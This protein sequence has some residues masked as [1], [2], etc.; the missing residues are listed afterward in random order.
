MPPKKKPAT[1]APERSAKWRGL[2][3]PC[4][5]PEYASKDEWLARAEVLRQQILMSTGLWPMPR[6]TALRAKVFNRQERD[7]Y[8][9]EKVYLQ[10]LPGFYLCGN[11]YRPKTGTGPHPGILCPHGHHRTGR[12]AHEPEA[13]VPGYCLGLAR[14]G[15]VS[16][17]YDMIGYNDTDQVPHRFGGQAEA[18]WGI[19]IM[20]LQLWNSI[21]AL[22]FLAALPDVDAQRLGCTGASGGGTQTFMLTAIDER[23]KV[24][25]PA[26]MIS[27]HMQGGCV[28]ENAPGLRLDTNN[29]EIG[30]LAAPR[31]MLM[32][33]ATGDWTRNT[34]TVEYPAVRG[35]YRLFKADK[36]LAYRIFD[37]PHNYNQASREAM[38]AWFGRWFL[39]RT[40]AAFA[41]EA[42][43]PPEQPRDLLVFYGRKPPTDRLLPSALRQ[44]L[45]DSS[46]RQ[47]EGA[48]P[49]S[50]R[51]LRR[52]RE[53]AG[54]ALQRALAAE[55][56][57]ANMI[58]TSKGG[59]RFT[60]RRE[61]K[62]D[63]V[64]ALLLQ[65]RERARRA[66]VLVDAAGKD[67]N[68]DRAPL[69]RALLEQGYAVLAIDCFGT[70]SSV[71]PTPKTTPRYIDTYN[72]TATALRVQDILT[73]LAWLAGS[74]EYESVSL[75]GQGE[76]GLWALLAAALAPELDCVAADANGFNT[77]RDASFLESL[78]IP[79]LRRAG[80]F[81][82]ACTLIQP[83][84]LLVHGT[85]GRFAVGWARETWRALGNRDFRVRKDAADAAA[86]CRWLTH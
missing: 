69:P 59:S 8:T 54:T 64:P 37:A 5:M 26:V 46:R 83:A 20:G 72:R 65:P 60:L 61:G 52:F 75:V 79:G 58:S 14:R 40:D 80:D 76:A 47:W 9:V 21:R 18:L 23:V 10:T 50:E 49:T 11:L 24:S 85:A 35:V 16:F 51:Q 77:R 53:L 31:P 55:W 34:A 82:S 78:Y 13:S 44:Y 84:R 33:A 48:K 70:G 25:V 4:S 73:A 15:F 1:V 68:D 43:F 29:M 3:T 22:D 12:L 39:D 81:N 38:Y 6:K 71:A 45:I 62:G 57:D 7:G 30:A 32:I 28:C 74:R 41:K 27:A 67:A 66:V 63:A 19:S 17:A 56:P 2:D 86:I 36:K 42:P